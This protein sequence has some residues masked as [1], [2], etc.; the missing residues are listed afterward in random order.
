MPSWF[1][2]CWIS[3]LKRLRSYIVL[4]H[5]FILWSVCL[6]T[7]ST[8]FV[9]LPENRVTLIY[10]QEKNLFLRFDWFNY[11]MYLKLW[12]ESSLPLFALFL[13]L[14]FNNQICN[15]ISLLILHTVIS[16][17]LID[18]MPSSFVLFVASLQS[19]K[20]GLTYFWLIYFILSIAFLKKISTSLFKIR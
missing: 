9:A 2:V 7:I 19:Y 14:S 8:G 18:N 17:V 15:Q 5:I 11:M 3:T 4:I 16:P 12:H 1:F 13:I 10:F 6:N 20:Y